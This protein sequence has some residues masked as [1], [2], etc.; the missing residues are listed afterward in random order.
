MIFGSPVRG[1][2]Y[3]SSGTVG[4]STRWFR[5]QAYGCTGFSW[6]PPKGSC[7]HY[8][9]GIDIARGPAGCNDDLLAAQSGTVIYAGALTSGSKSVVV[10][11]AG[12]YATGATHMNSI[13]VSRGQSVVRGQRLGTVGSTGYSTG[14]HDHMGLKGSFPTWA[15]VNE[16]WRDGVGTWLD[17]WP[18]LAQNVKV[19]PKGSGIN[20]R[21][22]PGGAI[23]AQTRSDGRIHRQSD[24]SDRGATSSWRG[25]DWTVTGPA[26]TVGGVRST[27]WEK[28]WLD[29][30]YRF[31]A[32]LLA[33][34]SV[35]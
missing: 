7:P 8:H 16:F 20:I 32:S 27:R 28:M 18:F 19:R 15:G 22:S 14:C 34:R 9:R 25:W 6:E 10:R 35:S 3:T 5:S 4:G 17:P 1:K 12:G 24:N 29:G 33:A 13:S 31:V 26:Y 21:N 2:I 23:Y 30:A 11:H